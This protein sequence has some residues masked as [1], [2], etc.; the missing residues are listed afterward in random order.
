LSEYLPFVIAGLVT[1]SVYGLAAVGL[2]LTY[3][4]SGVFNLAHGGLA[5]VA[6]YAF[7]S[8][9][10]QHGMPWPLAAA[11]V[12]LGVGPAMGLLLLIASAL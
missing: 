4:T 9:H 11:L 2:V 5:S 10:V 12:V 8:L 7:Y 6:A 1:G 3:K